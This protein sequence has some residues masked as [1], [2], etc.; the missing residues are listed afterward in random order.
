M[1]YKVSGFGIRF[2]SVYW[3]CAVT[4]YGVSTMAVVAEDVTWL[5]ASGMLG[6][7]TTWVLRS[8]GSML[9]RA[10]QLIVGSDRKAIFAKERIR[11]WV[12]GSVATTHCF[13]V[14]QTTSSV[15]AR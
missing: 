7:S 2:A 12:V 6:D 1:L 3:T 8:G 14:E 10:I 4:S 13:H 9:A 5:T 11:M 15:K